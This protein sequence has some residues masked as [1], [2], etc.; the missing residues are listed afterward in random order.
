MIWADDSVCLVVETGTL[1]F[2]YLWHMSFL[3]PS[4]PWRSGGCACLC[5]VELASLFL[6]PFPENLTHFDSTFASPLPPH[7]ASTTAL[8]TFPQAKGGKTDD[9]TPA[10]KLPMPRYHWRREDPQYLTPGTPLAWEGAAETSSSLPPPSLLKNSTSILA[11]CS[12]AIPAPARLIYHTL[13]HTRWEECLPSE[14]TM[15]AP[16]CWPWAWAGQT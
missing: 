13:A 16:L 5:C 8:H 12:L 4:P 11:S 6:P 10:I 1:H 9:K 15:L 7:T 3:P 14:K 2:P